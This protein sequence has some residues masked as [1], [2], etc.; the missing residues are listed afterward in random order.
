MDLSVRFLSGPVLVLVNILQMPWNIVYMTYIDVIYMS[1]LFRSD[2]VIIYKGAFGVRGS[3]TE[4]RA[5]EF[6]YYCVWEEIFWSV[7]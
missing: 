3:C 6:R 5:K 2:I 1:I 4:R 7:F